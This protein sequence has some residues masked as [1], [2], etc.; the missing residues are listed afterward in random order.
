MHLLELYALN[1]GGSKIDKCFILDKYFSLPFTKYITFQPKS[2]YDS[3][4]YDYWFEVISLLKPILDKE[5]IKIVQIGDKDDRQIEGTHF[6]SGQTNLGNVAFL[7]KNSL[8]NL[9]VDSFS[10]HIAGHYNIPLV[11]LIS[12][13]WKQAVQP[14][15]GDRDKQ[16]ILEPIRKGM[17]P[18]FSAV[19]QP[20]SINSISPEVVAS[21]VCS[22]LKLSFNF[23]YSSVLFGN[24]YQNKIVEGVLDQVTEVSR[25]GLNNLL[26]RMDLL[27]DENMLVRQLG[28]C[29]CSIITNRAI[30]LSI[31]GAMRERIV[32]VVY[33][34]DD[35]HNPSFV[36]FL[37][38]NNI[39]YTLI[40]YQ[41]DIQ[42]YKSYYM[43]LGI[44]HKQN[45]SKPEA[46]DKLKMENLYY[47]TNKFTLSRG[48][49]YPSE[50]AWH[51]DLPI[52]SF[53]S[54][55]QPIIDEEVFWKELSNF[56]ILEKV[57]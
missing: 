5:D 4:C 42:K 14:Y 41:S 57:S 6:V 56:Y 2:Q 30:N 52:N 1:S 29:P 27:F 53:N 19:E 10:A 51:K 3:K 21:S 40:S 55:P 36:E 26:V 17:K 11:D 39:K 37:Q 16:I 47:K 33:I 22:L 9:S 46:L 44:I 34:I 45:I 8:L 18:S 31:V 54:E 32:E 49:I 35:G 15:F 12:N 28:I 20:K 24:N 23:P 50:I 38:K 25:L 43:D 7:I 13:N 48:K